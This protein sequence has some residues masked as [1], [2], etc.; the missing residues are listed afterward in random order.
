MEKIRILIAEDHKLIR[1]TWTFILNS[2]SRFS[3][4][5]ACSD[6]AEAVELAEVKK[7]DVI[8]MDINMM[9]LNGFE[10]TAKFAI[11]SPD[12]KVIG[13][14]FYSEMLFVKKMFAAGAKGYVT[15]NS[16][17]EEMYA[18]ILAVHNNQL[19]VCDE[20]KSQGFDMNVQPEETDPAY[21]ESLTNKEIQISHC[22]RA[23]LRS[24]EIAD[25]MNISIKTVEV[26]RHNILRKLHVK[27]S[28]SLV[29]VMNSKNGYVRYSL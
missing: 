9:P 27:N 10:A 4:V 26:H 18:A 7:P 22:I 23:G 19:F 6:S 15:K 12:S 1:E 8:L 24:K 14:S 21:V 2:D 17:R 16:G 13:L 29:N 11:V 25:K 3:V 5:A 20:I 28:V